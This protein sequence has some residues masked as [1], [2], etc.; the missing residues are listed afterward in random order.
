MTGIIKTEAVVLSKI[1]YSNSSK[2]VHLYTKEF[3]KISAIVK[4]GRSSKSKIG[5]MVDPPNYLNIII[6]KKDTREIQLLSN[7]DIISHY[8]KLK[9]DFDKLKYCYAILELLNNLTSE[10]E[11][12]EKMFRGVIKILS[13]FNEGKEIPGILFGRFFLFFLKEIGY[14]LIIDNCTFCGKKN[15]PAGDY[16]FNFHLG[17]LCD[18]CRKEHIESFQL[19]KELFNY[20]FCLKNNDFADNVSLQTIERAIQFLEKYLKAHIPDFKGINAIKL[21]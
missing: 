1:D 17:V 8:P 19:N 21:K 6:Y 13:L 3:G 7:A 12:N 10:N 5:M 4:A 18:E 11:S 2:I 9:E 20:L 14:E 15:L 16:A